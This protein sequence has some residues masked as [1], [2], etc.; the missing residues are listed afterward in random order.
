MHA[1]IPPHYNLFMNRVCASMDLRKNI[2]GDRVNIKY[3]F[4]QSCDMV[5]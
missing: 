1:S 4:N 2:L 5:Y 3:S